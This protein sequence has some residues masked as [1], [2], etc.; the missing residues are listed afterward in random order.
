MLQCIYVSFFRLAIEK[1]RSLFSH[2]FSRNSPLR[3]MTDSSLHAQNVKKL[4]DNPNTVN[5]T[6]R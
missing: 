6:L 2:S 5:W 4:R 1:R 3:D